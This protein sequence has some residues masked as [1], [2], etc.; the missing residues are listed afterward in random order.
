MKVM[1]NLRKCLLFLFVIGIITATIGSAVTALPTLGEVTVN[2]EH[3]TRL[4]TVT[5][6]VNVIGEDIKTVKIAVLE[7]NASSGLCELNRDNVTMQFEEGSTYKGT[8]TLNYPTASYLS[9]WI[10]VQN[11]SCTIVLPN[12]E[13]VKVNLSIS[14]INGN[15]CSNNNDG[16]DSPGFEVIIF[17]AAICC[18]MILLGR[19]RFR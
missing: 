6:T 10:Y 13:G 11:N 17:I 18:M 8:V 1:K 19:K 15:N 9:Y 12:S 2:P 4:S 3:P 7:C 14:S 5:F 16:V